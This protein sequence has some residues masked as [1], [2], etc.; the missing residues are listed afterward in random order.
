MSISPHD[1]ENH[2]RAQLDLEARVA[3][4]D[5]EE[6]KHFGEFVLVGKGKVKPVDVETREI[7][8]ELEFD[9]ET[10]P[11]SY[12]EKAP[13]IDAVVEKL[14]DLEK[15]GI[16]IEDFPI[17]G[18]LSAKAV[19]RGRYKDELFVLTDEAVLDFEDYAI[20]LAKESWYESED[21]FHEFHAK[22]IAGPAVTERVLGKVDEFL[23]DTLPFLPSDTF[24]QLIGD[25]FLEDGKFSLGLVTKGEIGRPK[26][27]FSDQLPDIDVQSVKDSAESLLDDL[28][29][30]FR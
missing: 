10:L 26:V 15:Y 11:E 28:K 12:L 24:Q 17:G 5:L 1:L 2:N 6:G 25:N 23:S 20:E 27:S 3:F 4:D 8:P 22:L 30:I 19:L 21:N 18:S 9:L 7:D 14:G 13:I 29:S 16:G